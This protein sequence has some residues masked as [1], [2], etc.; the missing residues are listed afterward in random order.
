MTRLC[1]SRARA[2]KRALSLALFRSLA[3][4]LAWYLQTLSQIKIQKAATVA[5]RAFGTLL[6][7][8]KV[9]T[10]AIKDNWS[11]ENEIVFGMAQAETESVELYADKDVFPK[12]IF[13]IKAKDDWEYQAQDPS[14]ASRPLTTRSVLMEDA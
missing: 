3:F 8:N 14:L 6:D 5:R 7:M 1:R 2:G 4:S 9:D 10:F 12:M 11:D 13:K